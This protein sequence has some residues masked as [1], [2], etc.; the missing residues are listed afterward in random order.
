MPVAHGNG[1]ESG[2]RP[3]PPAPLRHL[4]WLIPLS[5]LALAVVVFAAV[6]AFHDTKKM[7]GSTMVQSAGFYRP[8]RAMPVS[9]SLPVLQQAVSGQPATSGSTS[10]LASASTTVT[11]ASLLGKP[12][13]L[14]MWSS[15]CTVCKAETPAMESVARRAGNAVRFVGVDTLDR[16]GTGLTFVHRYDVSYL[17]LFD[18]DEK[19]GAA[20]GIPGLPVTVFVSGGGKVVGE[21][22]GALSVK[23]LTHYL[24]VLFGVQVPAH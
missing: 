19:V 15:S 10:A 3:R 9:F 11:M 13:V 16:R 4:R 2:P 21:Y 12:V 14:N 1:V 17:Q 22:L 20:Y 8:A 24:G 7:T 23:S 18:A 5:A 6:E